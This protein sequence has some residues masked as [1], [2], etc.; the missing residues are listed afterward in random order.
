MM[1]HTREQPHTCQWCSRKLL[2]RQHL[3]T[4]MATH[5]AEMMHGSSADED[6]SPPTMVTTP[7]VPASPKSPLAVALPPV[8]ATKPVLSS[9]STT[10]PSKRKSS[11][12]S[13]KQSSPPK[14]INSSSPKRLPIIPMVT[15]ATNDADD[16]LADIITSMDA[17]DDDNMKIVSSLPS[18]YWQK[19]II[20]V[21]P[22]TEPFD[23]QKINGTESEKSRPVV[24]LKQTSR[25]K[26]PTI[27]RAK[28]SNMSS[29]I[30]QASSS[31]PR[32]NSSVDSV[33][34]ATVSSNHNNNNSNVVSSQT[35]NNNQPQQ[36][37]HSHYSNMFHSQNNSLNNDSG[38]SV[39]GTSMQQCP[40]CMVVEGELQLLK[41]ELTMIK[42][43]LG[44]K[45][46]LMEQK[47]DNMNSLIRQ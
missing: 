42:Q 33:S 2:V 26:C 32:T 6:E 16:E 9:S 15:T 1:S 23:T 10:V 11:H 39:V 30:R 44:S 14:K 47:I 28:S 45:L 36:Q 17:N 24:A 5:H 3:I 22:S 37:V 21:E 13:R 35:H 25:R 19:N 7:Q 27:S 40:N 31:S 20:K 8:E 43:F 18:D 34:S 12:K 4:H 29:I 38:V 41:T 46:T